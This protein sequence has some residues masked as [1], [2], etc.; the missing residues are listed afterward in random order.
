MWLNKAKVAWKYLPVRYFVS[1][2]VTWGLWYLVKSKGDIGGFFG[3]WGSLLRVPREERR[4]P[5]G[6]RARAYLK[7]VRARLAY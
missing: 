4:R 3:V 6:P 1:V 2:A 7:K 5:L